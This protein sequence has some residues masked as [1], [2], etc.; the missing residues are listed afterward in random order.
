MENLGL[1]Y[2][3]TRDYAAAAAMFD[4]AIK[5]APDAF[6]IKAERGWVDVYA[7]GDFRRLH[8]LLDAA[9]YGVDPSPV[10]ALTRFNVH[11]FER[12]FP[13]GLAALA[14][15]PFENMRGETSAPLPKPFL[16]AQIYRAMGDAEKAQSSYE[17]ARAIAEQALAVSPGDAARHSLL[18]LID[19]GL[20]RS[21]EAVSEGT[22][23]VQ[24]LPESVDAMDGPL[25]TIALARIHTVVTNHDR[26]LELL[27]H[28]HSTPSGI[29][30]SEL[31]VD[32]TWDPLRQ[33][34]RFEK[35]IEQAP[36]TP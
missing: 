30:T 29:T 19:A 6:E 27:E 25:L 22:R 12:K 5:L 8:E 31:R 32:P 1:N 21:E 34:P 4:N 9:P 2:N 14:K 23:A 26:A 36:T 33:N 28:S 11:F 20:G 15:T 3:A 35:L 18:G 24:I 17:Q 16:A 13:E 7:D 10:V